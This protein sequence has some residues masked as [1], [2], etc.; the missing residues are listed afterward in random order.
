MRRSVPLAVLAVAIAVAGC[1]GMKSD[2]PTCPTYTEIESSARRFVAQQLE[3][4]P[5]ATMTMEGALCARDKLVKALSATE[6][7]VVG[8]KAGLTNPAVQKR[9]QHDAPVRGTLFERSMVADGAEV[10]AKFGARPVWEADLILEVGSGS[11]HDATTPQ[12]VLASVRAIRP[13]I[14]LPDLV[15]QDPTKLNGPGIT[16]IN[17]GARGGVL[18]APIPVAGADPKLSDALRDMTVRVYDGT[19]KELASGKGSAI[20]EHPLNAAIWLAR[21]LKRAGITLK[22]GDMLSLGSFSPLSPPQPGQT[23]RVVYEG[24]PGNPAVSVKFR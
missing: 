6:G 14:E 9:F 12:Q 4:N 10:S 24:L 1:A 11:I 19:G 22:P 7:R 5:P 2:P 16:A 8:Y 3:P 18:G 13:F 17:V 23:I 20:L 21:D 15:V